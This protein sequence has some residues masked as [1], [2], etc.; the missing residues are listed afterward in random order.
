[1]GRGKRGKRKEER[2]KDKPE[3]RVFDL[4]FALCPSPFAKP[5]QV[6]P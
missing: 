5:F 2:G 1:M 4:P 3:A 6:H